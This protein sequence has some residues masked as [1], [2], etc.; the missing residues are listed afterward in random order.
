MHRVWH[1]LRIAVLNQVFG[2]LDELR[3]A[4]LCGFGADAETAMRALGLAFVDAALCGD[5]L[6]TEALA[7]LVGAMPS[8]VIVGYTPDDADKEAWRYVRIINRGARTDSG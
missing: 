4:Q 6:R 5:K 3:N 1:V 2:M 8:T 7:P